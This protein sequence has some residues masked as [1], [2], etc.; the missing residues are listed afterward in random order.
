MSSPKNDPFEGIRSPLKKWSRVSAIGVVL[1]GASLVAGPVQGAATNEAHKLTASDGAASDEFGHSVAIDGDIAVIGVRYGDAPTADSGS[2]YIF[3]VDEGGADN[4]GEVKKLTAGDGA[5]SDEFGYSVA[6]ASDTVVIGAPYDDVNG[7][8]SGSAYIFERNQGGSNIWGQVAK[9]TAGDGAASD[10]FGISVAIV[11]DTVVIGA[12]YDDVNG[13]NS[14]S[15][16][17]FGRNQGGSNV[18]GQVAKLTA[19][20]GAGSDNFGISVA[21]AGDTVVIGAPYDDDN[22]ENSGS[23]YIFEDDLGS[24]SEVK[25]LIAS[26][27]AAFDEF[28]YSVAAAGDTVVIGAYLDDDNGESSGSAYTFEIDEGGF[29][30][31]GQV[32]KLTASDGAASDEFGFSVAAAGVTIVIG[33][34]YDDDNF[35]NSGSAYV[36]EC[37]FSKALTQDVWFLI[38]IN[39]DPDGVTVQQAFSD[40]FT[41]AY[42][43]TWVLWERDEVGDVYGRMGLTDPLVQGE[44]YWIHTHEAGRTAQ[45]TVEFPV[46]AAAE[47]ASPLIAS[48][49]DGTWNMKGHP[50][51]D[52][53]LWADL[54]IKDDA[55]TVRS[56]AD[57]DAAGLIDRTGYT[58]PSGAYQCVDDTN[59][60]CLDELTKG[61]GFW[62]KAFDNGT[63]EAVE[64]QFPTGAAESLMALAEEA[65]SEPKGGGAMA[66][67]DGWAL[68]IVATSGPLRDFTSGLGELPDAFDGWDEND[69]VEL[70][71]D[72]V[73]PYLTVVFPHSDWGI[74]ASEW[75]T[76][77]FHRQRGRGKSGTWLLEVRSDVTRQ[78]T[79]SFEGPADVLKKGLLTDLETGW[80]YRLRDGA[81]TFT[82]SDIEHAFE[83]SLKG[84]RNKK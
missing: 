30:N 68:R 24:W 15:A 42:D 50:F 17:I 4:W 60:I 35:S 84:G 8:Y 23:A 43:D 2:A 31:W 38:G 62:I 55:D 14:G 13:G 70:R 81:M 52:T 12:P 1:I 53:A 5:A 59:V 78:V 82:M 57:A 54:N 34:S 22:G 77:D 11:G 26:D 63:A 9:L 33:V 7:G 19:G 18:W 36:F 83:F 66:E 72:E 45:F 37:D 39:C 25:K 44:G 64:I 40:D 21:A 16:Y 48:A 6:I 47:A 29:N 32:A 3:G 10:N 75:Y 56:L 41:G 20:D 61:E 46:T 67:F 71:P 58:W 73:P 74:D 51:N 76:T 65:S 79:L 28:G 49:G 80:K 27:G 69:L